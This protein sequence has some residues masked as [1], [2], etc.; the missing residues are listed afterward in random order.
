MGSKIRALYQRNKGRDLFDI[1]YAHSQDCLDIDKTIFCYREYMV[2]SGGYVPSA[3]QYIENLS[4]K[5]DNPAFC[6][7]MDRLLRPSINYSIREAYDDFLSHFA[8]AM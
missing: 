3:K 2:Q 8:V 5:L 6:V 1:Y 7:D 4:Q